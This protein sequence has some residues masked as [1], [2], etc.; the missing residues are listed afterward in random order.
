M[1]FL[2]LGLP[3]VWLIEPVVHTDPRGSFRRHFCAREFADHGIVPAVVQGNIST[4]TARGTLRGF[5]FQA[6]GAAEAKTMSCLSGAIHD[7]VIDLRRESPTFMQWIAVDVSADDCRSLHVP[8]GCANAWLTTAPNTVIHYYM[9]EQYQPG[10]ARGF[11]YD[12]A[13]FGVR[14]PEAPAVISEQDLAYPPFDPSL[15]G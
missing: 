12:D 14:W 6:G 15:L 2:E 9:S 3:G 4:N 5:H 8:A 10:S 1:K 11:R 7:I 13:A